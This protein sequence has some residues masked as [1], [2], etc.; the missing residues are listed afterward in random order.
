[1]TRVVGIFTAFVMLIYGI[2]I[3]IGHYEHKPKYI[4]GDTLQD[5][6]L[7][8]VLFGKYVSF[9]IENYADKAI[10]VDGGI[11]YEIYT[12]LAEIDESNHTYSYIQVMVKEEDTKQKLN[13]LK[14]EK[15]YFQGEVI[16][17]G[18]GDY[19]YD[20]AWITNFLDVMETNR[21]I[22]ICDYVIKE[23]EIP[24]E[25]YG[26]IGGIVLIIIA[27][28]IYYISGGIKTL[29]PTVEIKSDKFIE[30]DNVYCMNVHNINNELLC[31]KDNLKRLKYQQSESKKTDNIMTVIFSIGL[32]LFCFGNI[33]DFLKSIMMESSEFRV[34]LMVLV[35]IL[36][37]IGVILML[38]SIGGV[39]SRFIN[40]SHKLAVYIA[41]KRRKRSIYVEIEK[42]KKNIEYLEKI[43]D[44]KN[45]EELEGMLKN[46]YL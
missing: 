20:E 37:I 12:I 21:D 10:Y 11:E 41:V 17:I 45:K 40:S 3:I 29:W 42:C 31:E 33:T 30:Y 28:V 34:I 7:E 24:D 44:E 36:K 22:L 19:L 13:H 6:A 23:T 5:I 14:E 2:S 27:I 18:Y 4:E 15:V 38:I 43:I 9:Y 8:D 32:I 46:S 39:W 25:G 1:M 16:E 26:W 35:I